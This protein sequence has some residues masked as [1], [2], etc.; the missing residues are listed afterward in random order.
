MIKNLISEA[1]TDT[2]LN[3]SAIPDKPFLFL[4]FLN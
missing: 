4:F 3:A 1:A 2:F